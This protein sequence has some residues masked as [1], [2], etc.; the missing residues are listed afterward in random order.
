MYKRY[1]YNYIVHVHAATQ[2]IEYT[3]PLKLIRKLGDTFQMPVP[4]KQIS[5]QQKAPQPRRVY[6]YTVLI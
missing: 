1:N 4:E 3:D 5:I 6:T 2:K